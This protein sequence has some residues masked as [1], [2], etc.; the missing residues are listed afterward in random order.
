MSLGAGCLRNGA[1]TGAPPAGHPYD[2]PSQPSG[3]PGGIDPGSVDATHF[4]TGIDLMPT[5][6]EAVGLPLI[7]GLEGRSFLPLLM[8]KDQAD[9]EYQSEAECKLPHPLLPHFFV[10]PSASSDLVPHA[11]VDRERDWFLQSHL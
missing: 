11:S 8:G 9:R 7:E 3:G 2:T 6:M 1:T 4:V 5:I 10:P